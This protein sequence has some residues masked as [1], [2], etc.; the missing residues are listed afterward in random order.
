MPTMPVEFSVGAF[1][2]GHS[3]VREAYDWNAEFPNGGGALFFLFDFSRTSGT[4]GGFPTLPE[5]LDRRLA[6]ALPFP[7]D[8]P[9][10]PRSAAEASS[11]TPAASTPAWS[12]RSPTCRSGSF[13]GGAADAGT[14]RA[15]LAF[16]NLTRAGMLKLASGQQMAA[17]L[18]ARGVSSPSSPRHRSAM[19]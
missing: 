14:L 4:L 18:K 17:F 16:R 8:R 7:P 12:T 1:R 15:N 19:A 3:M 9:P 10:G 5:Q 6:P 11:T 13:G 2:L